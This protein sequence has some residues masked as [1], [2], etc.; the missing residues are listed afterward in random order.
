MFFDKSTGD[1]QVNLN[2]SKTPLEKKGVETSGST[3]QLATRPQL[4]G[5]VEKYMA[6]TKISFSGRA[7]KVREKVKI[8]IVMGGWGERALCLNWVWG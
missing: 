6:F 5:N 3:F 8:S 4:I 1:A 2:T 7:T